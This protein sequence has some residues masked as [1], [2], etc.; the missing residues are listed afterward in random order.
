[1]EDEPSSE[2][3][4]GAPQTRRNGTKARAGVPAPSSDAARRRMQATRQKETAPEQLL[5][6]ELARLGLDYRVDEPPLPGM[7]R[8]ADV[9]LPEPRVAVYVD[10]CFWHGCPTH[11]T[12]PKANAAFWRQKIEANRRRD[13]DTNRRLT[14]AGWL[15][16]RFWEHDD[17]VAAA[18]VIAGAVSERSRRSKRG[19]RG[20]YE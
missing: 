18:E 20:H 19:I 5:L 11:G 8:R 6:A 17:P 14:D 1:M 3:P 7:R 15:A 10:G 9:L 4:D 2:A 13:A 12:W 16:M